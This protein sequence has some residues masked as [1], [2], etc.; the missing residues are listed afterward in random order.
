MYLLG[1][2]RGPERLEKLL[3]SEVVIAEETLMTSLWSLPFE[4]LVTVLAVGAATVLVCLRSFG[5]AI[6]ESRR[7]EQVRTGLRRRQATGGRGGPEMTRVWTSTP[8]SVRRD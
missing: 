1:G 7:V 2:K 6:E 3:K 8:D 4:L 5:E